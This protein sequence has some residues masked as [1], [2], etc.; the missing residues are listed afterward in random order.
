MRGAARYGKSNAPFA[1]Q[2]NFSGMRDPGSGIRLYQTT[3]ENDSN[4]MNDPNNSNDPNDPNDLHYQQWTITKDSAPI[5]QAWASPSV[6]IRCR[7][8]ATTWR[9]AAFSGRWTCRRRA[10]AAAYASPAW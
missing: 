8:A 2:V 9:C 10:T 1:R 5:T 6:R 7:C 4:V 3:T